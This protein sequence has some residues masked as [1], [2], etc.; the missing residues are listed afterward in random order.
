M[1]PISKASRFQYVKSP[2]D[3]IRGSLMSRLDEA[4]DDYNGKLN[5]DKSDDWKINFK[6]YIHHRIEDIDKLMNMMVQLSNRISKNSLLLDE[7]INNKKNQKSDSVSN[8]L[9][10]LKTLVSENETYQSVV[11]YYTFYNEKF[12]WYISNKKLF[13]HFPYIDF[14]LTPGDILLRL[15]FSKKEITDPNLSS[16]EAIINRDIHIEKLF[17]VRDLSWNK[18][19]PNI[20]T[21]RLHQMCE[22]MLI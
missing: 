12:G 5:N 4:S 19:L 3:N 11:N 10:K 7:L 18:K 15:K 6:K 16:I 8:E 2:A 17:I 13:I 14:M 9:L 22:F 20:G 21:L 1:T